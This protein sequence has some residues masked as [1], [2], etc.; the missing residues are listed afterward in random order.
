[1]DRRKGRREGGKNNLYMN[2]WYIVA[3]VVIFFFRY[4]VKVYVFGLV[5]VFVECGYVV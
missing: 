1:M 3:R 5:Y 2:K 4:W